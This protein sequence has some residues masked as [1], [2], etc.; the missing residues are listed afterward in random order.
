[1]MS[2]SEHEHQRAAGLLRRVR[3]G[4]RGIA[5]IIDRRYAAK[6]AIHRECNESAASINALRIELDSALHREHPDTRL[7]YLTDTSGV[8]PEAVANAFAGPGDGVGETD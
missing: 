8:S 5:A 2:L 4:I 3:S 7:S 1:M 6:H